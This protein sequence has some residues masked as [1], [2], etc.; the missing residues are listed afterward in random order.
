[1]NKDVKSNSTI[2]C[3]LLHLSTQ[4]AECEN[5]KYH[6]SKIITPVGKLKSCIV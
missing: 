4:N 5:S 2:S 6:G 1:V 3:Y